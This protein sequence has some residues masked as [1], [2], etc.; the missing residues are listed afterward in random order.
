MEPL[1]MLKWVLI[2]IHKSDNC[3]IS[4]T[5]QYRL[6]CIVFGNFTDDLH[7]DF[8]PHSLED[9][10]ECLKENTCGLPN[11]ICINFPGGYDCECEDGFKKQEDGSCDV[12]MKVVW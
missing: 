2:V 6:K 3:F 4:Q 1:S 9:I 11:Q 12:G 7:S 10:N 8:E 5:L